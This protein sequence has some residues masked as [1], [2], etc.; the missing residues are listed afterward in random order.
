[1]GG[2]KSKRKKNRMIFYLSNISDKMLAWSFI[3]RMSYKW[4][5]DHDDLGFYIKAL[6]CFLPSLSIYKSWLILGDSLVIDLH[7]SLFCD[8]WWV[9]L[10][11]NPVVC[12]MPSVQRSS[13]RPHLEVPCIRP[14]IIIWII[15]ILSSYATEISHFGMLDFIV[16][17]NLVHYLA[18]Y[19]LCSPNSQKQTNFSPGLNLD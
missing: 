10:R 13:G 12:L 17:R 7:R 3:F 9:V 16:D 1:M 6:A 19:K 2:I 11:E 8:S 14:W 15:S 5:W 4:R 18:S